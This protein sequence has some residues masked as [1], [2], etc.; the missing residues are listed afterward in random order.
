VQ[1]SASYDFNSI[2]YEEANITSLY[3]DI[4]PG[5]LDWSNGYH[6]R[7]SASN[8]QGNP[9]D[10]SSPCF[11]LTDTA[12]PAATANLSSSQATL[13]ASA[14]PPS[15]KTVAAT[16][17]AAPV[18]TLTTGVTMNGTSVTFQWSS[19][20][21]ATYYW[22]SVRKISDGTYIMDQ[23]VGDVTTYTMTG[24]PNDDTQYRWAV[25]AGN[26]AGWN[27]SE[28]M[29]FT[30]STVSASPAPILNQQDFKTSLLDTIKNV[31]SGS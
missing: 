21:G 3:Y 18:Q 20:D 11:F 23:N 27:T 4:P 24:I 14:T 10:W 19:S 12:R 5:K 22:L 26:S 28:Y 2:L 1:I 9:S 31:F 16:I 7:V 13:R 8:T 6:W 30:S 25:A 17:P 29:T 15:I